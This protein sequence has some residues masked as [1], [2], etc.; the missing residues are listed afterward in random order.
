MK[1][2][3]CEIFHKPIVVWIV[4]IVNFGETALLPS[5]GLSWPGGAATI[6][7]AVIFLYERRHANT[8][9]RFSL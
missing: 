3:L 4:S 9:T 1:S 5:S 2:Q 7:V 6:I 8:P